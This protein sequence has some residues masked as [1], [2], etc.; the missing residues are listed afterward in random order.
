MYASAGY[1]QSVDNLAQLV[2]GDGQRLRATAPSQ[3]LAT[4]TGSVA[5][6]YV[7]TLDL[8]V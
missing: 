3:Q 7:A 6:G 5:D 8:A 4:M 1:E 2:A